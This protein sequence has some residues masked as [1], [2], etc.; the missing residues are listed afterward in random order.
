MQAVRRDLLHP[1][2]A[3]R[4]GIRAVARLGR[5]LHRCNTPM[6]QVTA[7]H[8]DTW[9]SARRRY[10]VRGAIGALP[11]IPMSGTLQRAWEWAATMPHLVALLAAAALWL[12]LAGGLVACQRVATVHPVTDK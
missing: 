6:S 7:P 9:F 4:A 11:E 12:A 1:R 2:L 10:P 8:G 3:A 5:V